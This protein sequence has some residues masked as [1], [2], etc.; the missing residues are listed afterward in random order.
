[1]QVALV[2]GSAGFL[3]SRL[4]ERLRAEGVRVHALTRHDCDLTD[5]RAVRDRLRD[6]RPHVAFHLAAAMSRTA[7]DPS[8]LAPVNVEG[9]RHLLASLPATTRV[10]HTGTLFEYGGAE[11]PFRED[12][13]CS[14]GSA[15]GL[16]KRDAG[17]LVTAQGGSHVHL[18]LVYGPGQ[19]DEFLVP[20][21]LRARRTG[22]PLPMTE[23]AQRRDFLWVEDAVEG[24]VRIA[25]SPELAGRRVNLCTGVPTPLRELV[26]RV[27]APVRLGA[28][29]YRPD[30]IFDCYGSPGLLEDA[31]GWRP[32]TTLQEGLRRLGV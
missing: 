22:E 1:M 13:P 2:T 24:L 4:V 32:R 16:T 11:A 5:P 10:V 19:S 27:G 7:R 3:G 31:T 17:R 23:G 26:H 28:L 18:A 12:Q 20:Q 15:Y 6:L 29:P 25:G 21:L 14:P 30:E 9:T 8:E